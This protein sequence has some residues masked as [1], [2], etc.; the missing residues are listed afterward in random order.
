M[1]IEMLH[2]AIDKKRNEALGNKVVEEKV[3][4]N[5]MLNIDAYIPSK[6]F[7]NDYEKID[8]YKRIDKVKSL[9]QLNELKEEMIDKTGKLP[10]SIDLLFEKKVIDLY[11]SSGVI[12]SYDDLDKNIVIKLS[13]EF[14][15]YKNVGISIF[16]ISNSVSNQ[17]S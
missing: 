2:N 3:V 16:E 8:L 12:D 5:K 1:Y 7:N 9:Q 10:E 14:M 4:F 6:Y 13:K 11:I 17:I 15:K